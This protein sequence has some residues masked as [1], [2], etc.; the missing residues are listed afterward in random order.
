MLTALADDREAARE[1]MVDVF[2]VLGP[3]DPL[4]GT[5]RAKLAAAL[6]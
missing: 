4:V 5:Y 1:A 3:D 6:F 2:G